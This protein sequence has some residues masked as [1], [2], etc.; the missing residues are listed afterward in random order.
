MGGRPH[1]G[2]PHLYQTRSGMPSTSPHPKVHELGHKPRQIE[3]RPTY[4]FLTIMA[5]MGWIQASLSSN[6][7]PAF[8]HRPYMRKGCPRFILA[9][10]L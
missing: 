9:S 7:T 2:S 10:R 1:P 6:G 4:L 5:L 3:G 8:L